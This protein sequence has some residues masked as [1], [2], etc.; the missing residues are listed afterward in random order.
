MM[1]RD[2]LLA[3]AAVGHDHLCSPVYET[4]PIDCEPGTPPFLN[5]VIEFGT[6]KQPQDL[7]SMTKKIEQE[8]GRPGDHGYHTPRTVDLDLLYLD[9]VIVQSE[10][11]SLPHPRMTSRRFVMQPLEAIRPDLVLPGQLTTVQQLLAD[12]GEPGDDKVAE[13]DCPTWS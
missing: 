11:L 6:T 3:V 13:F 12:L 1:A 4:A 10:A 9:D 8:L 2:R 7:L 5:A